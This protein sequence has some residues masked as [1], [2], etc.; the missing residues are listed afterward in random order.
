M[1]GEGTLGALVLMAAAMTAGEASAQALQ[2][3]EVVGTWTLTMT[4]AEGGD[5]NITI[6]SDNGRLEVPLIVSPSGPSGLACTADG[7]PADCQ[8]RRGQLVVTLSMDAARMAFT[9]AS[10]TRSGFAGNAR[11]RLPLLPFGSV[12]LGTVAMTRR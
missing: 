11:L 1:A 9:L 2:R 4:P 12:H 5:A 6:Q 8:L 7:E 10:R 3:G